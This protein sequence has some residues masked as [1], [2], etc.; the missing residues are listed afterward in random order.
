MSR[1][2]YMFPLLKV[3]IIWLYQPRYL[4]DKFL[5]QKIQLLLTGYIFY[6]N[7]KF[8]IFYLF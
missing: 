5:I 2:S 3:A 4:N 1:D 7:T 6:T 8:Y